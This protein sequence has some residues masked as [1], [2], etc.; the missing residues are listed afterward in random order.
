MSCHDGHCIPKSLRCNAE[1]NCGEGYD[2]DCYV[3]KYPLNKG[4][5]KNTSSERLWHSLFNSIF[6][7]GNARLWYNTTFMMVWVNFRCYPELL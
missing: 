5:K 3:G 4:L 2:E 1:E 6:S 7:E